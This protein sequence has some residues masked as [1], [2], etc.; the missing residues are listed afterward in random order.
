MIYLLYK[1]SVSQ[2][3]SHRYKQSVLNKIIKLFF[4]HIYHICTLKKNEKL[5]FYSASQISKK[6]I[7]FIIFIN[8]GNIAMYTTWRETLH[9]Y[10]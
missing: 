2:G 7:F 10:L 6:N 4:L 5:L 3:F 1:Q 8:I 9:I